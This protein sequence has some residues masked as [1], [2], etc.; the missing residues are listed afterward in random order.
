MESEAALLRDRLSAGVYAHSRRAESR[1]MSYL[2]A[3]TVKCI[4]FPCDNLHGV[5]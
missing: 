1:R 5:E 4:R 3:V 2:A